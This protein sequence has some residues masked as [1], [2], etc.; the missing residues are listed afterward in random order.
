MP[1]V[2][3]ADAQRASPDEDDSRQARA[4]SAP[5][6]APLTPLRLGP[7]RS[8]YPIP[9]SFP[10]VP[11][12]GHRPDHD[13]SVRTTSPPAH[14]GVPGAKTQ[15]CP[16]GSDAAELVAAAEERPQRGGL[17]GPRRVVHHPVA[18][19]DP[20]VPR[21]GATVEHQVARLRV[22]HRPGLGVL[23]VRRP[24]Q[25]DTDLGEDVLGEAGAVEAGRAS[26]R[27]RRTGCR[28]GS[29]RHRAR[30][31]RRRVVPDQRPEQVH[32]TRSCSTATR[33]ASCSRTGSA[34]RQGSRPA[35]GAAGASRRR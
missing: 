22:R 2:F 19:V 31:R 28:P 21:R 10:D 14:R 32:S 24:S 26:S 23:R 12:R 6:R 13:H 27:R 35:A 3:R 29:P 30:R 34:T 33:C 5:E 7:H 20:D 8:A 4:G 9:M 15:S 17:A 1:P 11:L 18:G 25:G 16:D